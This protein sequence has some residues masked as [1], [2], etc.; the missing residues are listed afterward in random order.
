MPARLPAVLLVPLL[1]VAGCAGRPCA[2]LP[3]ELAERDAARAAYLELVRQG[4]PPDV[5]EREDADLHALE[6]RVH[7]REQ[8]CSAR[9]A[10]TG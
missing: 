8:S 2:D 6:R 4:A 9:R 5:T 10:G 7:E 1:L 3:A